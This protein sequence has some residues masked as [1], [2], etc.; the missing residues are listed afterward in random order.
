MI[1]FKKILNENK[2]DV[3]KTLQE[4]I[5]IPSVLDE[6]NKTEDAPF[7]KEVRKALDYMMARAKK[8]GFETLQDGGYAG[9]LEY[10]NKNGKLI[11]ILCHLD[12]VPV[13]PNWTYP[14]FSAHITD[15]NKMYGRG[16]TD[17]KGP[18][19]AAYFALKFIKDAGIK[20]KNNVRIIFGCDEETGWRGI[21][22][23]LKHY[24]APDLGF[25][26]D[27]DFPLIY[28]EKG[29]MSY[30]LSLPSFQEDDV[31]VSINGGERYN[32]V[33][34][35]VTAIIKKDLRKEFIQFAEKNKL[36]YETSILDNNYKLV[37]KGV[38]SHAMEPEKGINAGT[39]MC[40]FLKDYTNN[41]MV[42]FVNDYLHLDYNC[43][44]LGLYY[45]DYEMGPITD[46]LGI[47]NISKDEVR[48]T[49]DLRYPV[50]YD[51][52]KFDETLRA[53]AEEKGLIITHSTNKNPH[54]VDPND[55]LVTKLYD[56]YLK[57]TNDFE[58][59]PMTIG[60]GTY[61]STLPKAVAFGMN[62]PYEE[63]L[64]HQ[65]DEYLNLE[66]YFK[67]ILIY[68]DAILALG[69]IDA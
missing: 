13:G 18:T 23:Y 34:E 3:I 67:A 8:D 55:E 56:V 54:Y 29:R 49:L 12:V 58:H 5:Q 16:S 46:N 48:V 2:E 30:D 27:A 4:L 64:A 52:V 47:M 57:H 15:D 38:A 9:H 41:K 44:K 7:G 40:N 45:N 19:M 43:Q 21:T 50:R 33:L 28:G 1:D 51:N 32:V 65:R 61:A 20:L 14:P 62:M 26:P 25:V 17:D 35:E 36:G 39:Y 60:G 31:L 53:I 22:H 42:H 37:L 6:N 66:T 68:V 63:E 59:K 24:P 69:E 11:G 10:G